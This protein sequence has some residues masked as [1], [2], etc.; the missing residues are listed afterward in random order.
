MAER[1]L[2]RLSHELE[3]PSF[4]RSWDEICMVGG[5]KERCDLSQSF[6][7]IFFL[8]TLLWT[9]RTLFQLGS[10]AS[11]TT[12]ESVMGILIHGAL[13]ERIAGG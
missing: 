13:C 6:Q 7:D 8:L 2:C 3:G 5:R 1:R 11:S 4:V 12:S 9:R 10:C